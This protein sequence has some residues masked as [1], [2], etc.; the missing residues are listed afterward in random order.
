M[1][2]FLIKYQCYLYFARRKSESKYNGKRKVPKCHRG[3]TMH[4]TSTTPR[5]D[6]NMNL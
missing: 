4:Q 1:Y 6:S 2:L 3:V 5:S